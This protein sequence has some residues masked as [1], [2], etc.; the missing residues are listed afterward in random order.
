MENKDSEINKPSKSWVIYSF[1]AMCFLLFTNFLLSTIGNRAGP[2]L[3]CYF[4]SGQAFAGIVFNLYEWRN[5][6]K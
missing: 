4:S 6:Y 3:F 1:V 5:Q 2:Y